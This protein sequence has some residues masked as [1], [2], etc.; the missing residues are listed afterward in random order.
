[1][2]CC[3]EEHGV[4]EGGAVFCK[5]VA[6]AMADLEVMVAWCEEVIGDSEGAAVIGKAVASAVAEFEAVG[7]EPSVILIGGAELEVVK[8][9]NLVG[10]VTVQPLE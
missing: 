7:E 4:S 9:G 6:V 1:M 3:E 2:A 5:T 10:G 8:E